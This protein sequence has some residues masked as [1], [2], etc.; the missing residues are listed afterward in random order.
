MR[1][2]A[3]ETHQVVMAGLVPAIH[4]LLAANEEN[5]DARHKAGMTER[6]RYRILG[7]KVAPDLS[8]HYIAQAGL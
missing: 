3:K 8:T 1:G 4:V 6:R 2:T 5:V 7:N